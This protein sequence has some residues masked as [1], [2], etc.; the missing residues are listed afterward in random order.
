[1]DKE[2]TIYEMVNYEMPKCTKIPLSDLAQ[3]KSSWGIPKYTQTKI[4]E[5]SAI[6]L[7]IRNCYKD[8]SR[9]NQKSFLEKSGKIKAN[10]QKSK[11]L[12]RMLGFLPSTNKSSQRSLG[13]RKSSKQ[14]HSNV[15]NSNLP[16]PLVSFNKKQFKFNFTPVGRVGSFLAKISNKNK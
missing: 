9:E 1:M 11:S 2:L 12:N 5:N 13:H 8:V 14:M 4:F 3:H 15:N 10:K 6:H 16:A 7:M